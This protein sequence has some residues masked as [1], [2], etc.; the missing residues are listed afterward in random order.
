MKTARAHGHPARRTGSPLY[1]AL[2]PARGGRA[3]GRK[4]PTFS[5]LGSDGARRMSGSV[6]TA[7][8]HPLSQSSRSFG[9]FT[10]ARTSAVGPGYHPARLTRTLHPISGQSVSTKWVRTSSPGRPAVQRDSGYPK[11]CPSPPLSPEDQLAHR[12][13]GGPPRRCAEGCRASSP[14]PASRPRPRARAS[15]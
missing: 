15:T 11:P 8:P 5:P 6:H 12:C 9:F 14:R 1:R 2:S 3:P 10:Q 7:L 13:G 4:N